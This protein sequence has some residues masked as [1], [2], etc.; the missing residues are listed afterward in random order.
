[1]CYDLKNSQI[2]IGLA[3]GLIKDMENTDESTLAKGLQ[4]LNIEEAQ[5]LPERHIQQVPHPRQFHSSIVGYNFECA[6]SPHL[7]KAHVFKLL[8]FKIPPYSLDFVNFVGKKTDRV[9]EALHWL[10]SSFIAPL[11][12]GRALKKKKS[13]WPSTPQLKESWIISTL[14]SLRNSY[15][16]WF[17]LIAI[18]H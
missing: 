12:T 9:T 18:K 4:S 13:S 11:D 2:Y 15:S 14:P 17:V 1:M 10:K 5:W 8:T 7:G 3:E 6:T 16:L